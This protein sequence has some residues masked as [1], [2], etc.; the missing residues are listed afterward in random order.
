MLFNQAVLI[1][2]AVTVVRLLLPSFVS[3][4][5]NASRIFHF[6]RYIAHT[7]ER[8]YFKELKQ[9]CVLMISISKRYIF[10]LKLKSKYHWFL[11]WIFLDF[12]QLI[13]KKLN[14][15]AVST[16]RLIFLIQVRS[17]REE[18]LPLDELNKLILPT[19]ENKI[20]LVLS[21]QLQT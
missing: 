20:L 6:H 15:F 18:G 4:N 5:F 11:Q 17:Q 12:E 8:E 1:K 14:A 21:F 3:K 7:F 10:N 2:F 13:G 9:I 19:T 16:C